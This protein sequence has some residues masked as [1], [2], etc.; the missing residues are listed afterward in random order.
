MKNTHINPKAKT[1]TLDELRGKWLTEKYRRED[2]ARM[3]KEMRRFAG[4]Y[5]GHD[6]TN[7]NIKRGKKVFIKT[8]SGLKQLSL[9]TA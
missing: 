1:F 7:M 2:E 6:L 4:E 3:A 5:N 9:T 8:T